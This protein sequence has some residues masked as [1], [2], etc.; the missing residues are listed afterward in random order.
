MICDEPVSS[1]DVSVQA[2]VM[3]LLMQLQAEHGTS[4]LFISH[5]LSVVRYL[6]DIVA[7]MYLGQVVEVSPVEQLFRPPYHPYAETLLAAVPIPDPAFKQRRVRLRGS[8]PSA[9]DPPSGC[10]FHTRCPRKVGGICE[11]EA[12]P[13]QGN[14]GQ[15]LIL[16]HIPWHDLSKVEAVL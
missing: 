16:C 2:A 9:I 15:K 7:V 3:N 10:R 13:Q 1:L 4:Y 8:V 6:A 5:D 11:L 12:P 14:P